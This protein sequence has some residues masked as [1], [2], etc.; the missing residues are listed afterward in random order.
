MSAR[1][2]YAGDVSSHM[3]SDMPDL[4]IIRSGQRRGWGA[5]CSLVVRHGHSA[6]AITAVARALAGEIRRSAIKEGSRDGFCEEVR[7]VLQ[8]NLL[9]PTRS[10]SLR[11]IGVDELVRREKAVLDALV[12]DIDYL[13]AQVTSG[14]KP[15]ARGRVRLSATDTL[16]LR[17]GTNSGAR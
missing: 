2:L 17:I 10:R 5:A 6:E 15:K 8:R 3:V 1:S 9:G 14:R 11:E 16:S 13:Y 4:D 12:P 7:G